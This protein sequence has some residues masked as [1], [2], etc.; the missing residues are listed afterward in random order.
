MNGLGLSAAV[1]GF[2]TGFNFGKSLVGQD[3]ESLN[4]ELKNKIASTELALKDKALNEDALYHQG[5]LAAQNYQNR[6]GRL[7]V[8]NTADYQ[9]GVLSGQDYR[10][11]TDR[12]QTNQQGQYQQGVLANQDRQAQIEEAKLPSQIGRENAAARLNS[13]VTAQNEWDLSQQKG[14]D[15][16][17]SDEERFS[18]DPFSVSPEVRQR[19]QT[20]FQMMTNPHAQ[21]AVEALDKAIAEMPTKGEEAFTPEVRNRVGLALQPLLSQGIGKEDGAG[22]KTTDIQFDR[23]VPAPGGVKM[24]V[25]VTKASKETDP[26]GAPLRT[27]THSAFIT[28][29]RLAEVDGGQATTFSPQM[30]HQVIGGL[31]GAGEFQSLHPELAQDMHDSQAAYA[32]AKT[33]ADYIKNRGMIENARLQ[34]QEKTA[35][36][37]RKQADH[38]EKLRSA[39]E[40]DALDSL[41]N[42]AGFNAKNFTEDGRQNT[43]AIQNIMKAREDTVAAIRNGLRQM[44]PEQLARVNGS[45]ILNTQAIRPL[46]D[47]F[48]SSVVASEGEPQSAPTRGGIQNPR[49]M[50]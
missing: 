13:S 49:S 18:E 27:A 28:D 44:T 23:F 25:K 41:D 9:K 16:E 11:T 30:V 43:R 34:G 50:R 8:E 1:N 42:V 35:E 38:A 19:I 5:V 26:N 17:R 33:R 29:G 32:G 3:D 12:I 15:Q 20:K 47:T 4:R 37:E 21:P 7:G 31:K 6:T 2:Q 36:T 14:M 46:M 40:K 39:L 22:M 10:N 45:E 24:Q 48:R